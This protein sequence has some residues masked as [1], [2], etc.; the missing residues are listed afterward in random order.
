ML[1]RLS[2]QAILVSN[3]TIINLLSMEPLTTHIHKLNKQYVV[4]LQ[5]HSSPLINQ[6]PDAHQGRQNKYK[7]FFMSKDPR[8][9]TQKRPRAIQIYIVKPV[10]SAFCP[11]Q[12][13]ALI[14][15][16]LCLFRLKKIK[17]YSPAVAEITNKLQ[18]VSF[19]FPCFLVR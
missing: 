1:R 4:K 13:S 5:Q 16:A 11:A 2:Y 3:N 8:V 14:K 12:L 17:V 19:S 6:L 10:R 15:S 9:D 18:T 7:T